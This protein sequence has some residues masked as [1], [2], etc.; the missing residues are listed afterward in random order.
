MIILCSLHG[1]QPTPSKFFR[2]PVCTWQIPDVSRKG[3]VSHSRVALLDKE[4]DVPPDIY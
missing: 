2:N 3:H 4:D 1:E